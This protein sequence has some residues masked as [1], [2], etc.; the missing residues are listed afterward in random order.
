MCHSITKF[1]I[2]YRIQLKDDLGTSV[3]WSTPTKLPLAVDSESARERPRKRDTVDINTYY[4]NIGY[5]IMILI[6]YFCA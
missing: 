3:F 6:S 5:I 1:G 4:N 2:P